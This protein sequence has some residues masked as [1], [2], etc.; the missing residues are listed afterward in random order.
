M[1][2][3]AIICHLVEKYGDEFNWRM[4]PSMASQGAFVDELK[5]ELGE[6]SDIFHDRIYAVAKCDS[7]D[8]VL[9]LI[10]DG[11]TEELWRIYHL[12]YTADNAPGFPRY[13]EFSNGKAVGDFIE[14]QF[15]REF[16]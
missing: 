12:T 7:A 13:Q 9:F 11:S 6:E 16:L 14:D 10:G 3:E 2:M 4:I 8:D 15:V 5:R 1:T